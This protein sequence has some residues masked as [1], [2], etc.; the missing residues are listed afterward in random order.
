MKRFPTGGARVRRMNRLG[1][2][3]RHP[4]AGTVKT[5]L[6]PALPAAL[7]ARL[8]EAML[9]DTR[10]EAAACDA[11][12]TWWW[13]DG[14]APLADPAFEERA[15]EGDSLGERLA[16]AMTAMRRGDARSRAVIVGSDCPALV[17]GHLRDAFAALAHTDVV[18]GPATDGGY[19][20]VGARRECDALFHD[21]PWSTVDVQGLCDSRVGLSRP[22]HFSWVATGVTKLFVIAGRFRAYFCEKA[23]QQFAVVT[24]LV[25]DLSNPVEVLWC[26][27][28]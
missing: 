15:Q 7:A 1:V 13:A 17:A 28:A 11:A 14:G 21:V 23:F 8:Y 3:A 27:I 18:L 20:L 16:H 24:D 2:F 19:W 9:A 22:T 4:V 6:S 5:R 10:A 26:H 25:A 12:R